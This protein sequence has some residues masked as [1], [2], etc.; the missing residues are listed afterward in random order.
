MVL[1]K[2]KSQRRFA[3]IR[4]KR[5]KALKRRR[6][7]FVLAALAVIF[8]LGFGL[9]KAAD[10]IFDADARPQWMR[11]HLKKINIVGEEGAVVNEI[12]KY[13]P[14][15]EGEAL[16]YLD[17]SALENILENNLKE[18][19]RVSVRRNFFNGDLNISVKKR[20]AFARLAADKRNYLFTEDGFIFA[21]E[22]DPRYDGLFQVKASGQIKD[23]LLPKEFVELVKAV[24]TETGLPVKDFF[25]DFDESSF[26]VE[27]EGVRADMGGIKN[28]ADKIKA[29]KRILEESSARGFKK[30]FDINFNYFSDGKIYLKPSA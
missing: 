12:E 8:A 18:L 9:R 15:K 22:Q 20:E 24:K 1:K 6:I 25:V 28:G 16:S 30:P 13:I 19:D 17:C 2:K 26:K 3:P 14:F 10:L 27:L 11:W 4:G 21:D 29:L 7:I 23:D 5:E